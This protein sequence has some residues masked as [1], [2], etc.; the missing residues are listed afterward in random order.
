[1]TIGIIFN[2]TV[3]AV[4]LGGLVYLTVD[5]VRDLMEQMR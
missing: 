1:M 3:W 2:A 5:C 4:L